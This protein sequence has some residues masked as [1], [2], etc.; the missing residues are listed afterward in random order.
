L[1]QQNLKLKEENEYLGFKL[2]IAEEKE[3]VH[4]KNVNSLKE[5]QTE[6]E[7]SKRTLLN[8]YRNKEERLK[9]KYDNF[10]DGRGK[11]FKDKETELVAKLDR[12]TEEYHTLVRSHD[13]LEKERD[14]MKET[15]LK[16]DRVVRIK[17]DEYE[18]ALQNKENRINEMEL[19]VRSITEE[20]NIQITKLSNSLVE[21]NNKLTYYKNREN[22]LNNEVIKL[23]RQGGYITDLNRSR[24]VTHTD[25]K[26]SKLEEENRNLD[27]TIEGLTTKLVQQE[28]I[29]KV[30]SCLILGC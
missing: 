3:K 8:E 6:Y 25:T 9:K 14:N 4:E 27:N 20:A 30:R 1:K 5:L 10:E 7:E 21:F 13:K 24:E 16:H 22:E 23:Q 17:E 28:A 29:L 19:Y 11:K 2:K 26:M 12:F 18:Q 15:I